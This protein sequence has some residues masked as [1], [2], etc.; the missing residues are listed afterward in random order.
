VTRQL[1]SI[2]QRVAVVAK[3][4]AVAAAGVNEEL[5]AAVPAIDNEEVNAEPNANP[6][7]NEDE[8]NDTD[9][10]Y[11]SIIEKVSEDNERIPPTPDDPTPHK[12]YKTGTTIRQRRKNVW[13]LEEFI[14]PLNELI[15]RID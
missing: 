6:E 11:N 8:A 4:N 5:E 14:D 10:H 15:R 7:G 13:V 9:E 2:E 12:M 1:L 3:G